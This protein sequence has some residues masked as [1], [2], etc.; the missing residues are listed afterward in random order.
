MRSPLVALHNALYTAL[1]DNVS[2]ASVYAFVPN[3]PSYPYVYI[4]EKTTG[5]DGGNKTS[6]RYMVRCKLLV[7][8]DSDNI[9]DVQGIIDEIVDTALSTTLT[10]TDNWTVYKQS[11][12]SDVRAFPAQHFDGS[13]GHAAEIFYN[14][15]LLDT[16]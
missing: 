11:E 13:Q 10:L 15:I 3:P 9:N 5:K 4:D 16:A 6:N 14:F 8:T 2:S 7:V 1:S 12:V